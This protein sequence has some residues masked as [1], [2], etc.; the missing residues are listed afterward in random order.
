MLRA[1]VQ[2]AGFTLSGLSSTFLDGQGNFSIPPYP[3]G[4][5]SGTVTSVD[6]TGPVVEFFVNGGPV[7]ASG[8]LNF[9][10][11]APVVVAHG[12]TGM[13]SFAPNSLI[14]AGLGSSGKFQSTPLNNLSSS[15]LDGGGNFS[16][17]TGVKTY[18]LEFLIGDASNV[19]GLAG[20]PTG[21]VRVP[22][23]GN[24]TGWQILSCDSGNPTSGSIVLD[25]FKDTY[26][27]YPPTAAD[28]IVGGAFPSVTSAT[29]N[30]SSEPISNWT[31]G[32]VEGDILYPS[33][34]SVSSFKAVKFIVTYLG[35]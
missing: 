11:K 33:V 5:G 27:N 12:G 23:S 16:F 15:F 7:T 13:G 28:S 3:V 9:D 32:L 34:Q 2:G 29:K 8:T 30:L 17:P 4:A 14:R 35:F 18:Q 20:K 26:A 1:L 25:L 19:I 10:W 31:A 6:L 21:V 24:I 22:R